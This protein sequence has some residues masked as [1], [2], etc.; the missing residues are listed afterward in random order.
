MAPEVHVGG[1]VVEVEPSNEQSGKFCYSGTDVL[2]TCK[3]QLISISTV[4]NFKMNLKSHSN[5]F[6]HDI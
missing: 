4:L 1:M 6:S 3:K 2:S 5:N